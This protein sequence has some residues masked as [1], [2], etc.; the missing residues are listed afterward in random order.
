MGGMGHLAGLEAVT[1]VAFWHSELLCT[2]GLVLAMDCHKQ[3]CL[4]MCNEVITHCVALSCAGPT[5][6]THVLFTGPLPPRPS[7]S[8]TAH[9]KGKGQ[10]GLRPSWSPR[11]LLLPKVVFMARARTKPSQW[12]RMPMGH[13]LPAPL[14]LRSQAHGVELIPD[15]AVKGFCPDLLHKS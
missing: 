9:G 4:C 15:G 2:E 10:V 1:T 6:A 7:T 12:M 13:L 5:C 3:F 14:I 8:S 11:S